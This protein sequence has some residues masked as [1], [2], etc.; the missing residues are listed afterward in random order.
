MFYGI[1]RA[2]GEYTACRRQWVTTG[3]A[4]MAR[5]EAARAAE[6]KAARRKG[7]RMRKRGATE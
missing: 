3:G 7:K 5:R 6:K 4:W 2:A 1:I